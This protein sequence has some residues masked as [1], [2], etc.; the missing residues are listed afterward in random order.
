MLMKP[1]RPSKARNDSYPLQF[2]LQ[3]ARRSANITTKS[4]VLLSAGVAELV[5]ARD[6]KSLG[7]QGPCRFDSGP[8]HQIPEG[9]SD[10]CRFNGFASSSVFDRAHWGARFGKPGRCE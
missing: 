9:L 2:P 5:D 7:P 10:S 8:P 4:F 6:L 1:E 3:S